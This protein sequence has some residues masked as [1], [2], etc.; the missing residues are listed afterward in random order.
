M[1]FHGP[2][3]IRKIVGN[4]RTFS[5]ALWY[6]WRASENVGQFS[7]NFSNCYNAIWKCVI[8]FWTFPKLAEDFR[9]FTEDVLK[10]IYRFYVTPT[11]PTCLLL[12]NLR[13]HSGP[14]S[15][16]KKK[17]NKTSSVH[18]IKLLQ[19]GRIVPILTTPFRLVMNVAYVKNSPAPAPTNSKNKEFLKKKKKGDRR[20]SHY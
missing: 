1:S 9:Q 15:A 7:D 10:L 16:L 5:E 17:Y 18:L 14:S 11:V 2:T 8:N 20:H 19:A 13:N 4:C 12:Q 3:T 6:H